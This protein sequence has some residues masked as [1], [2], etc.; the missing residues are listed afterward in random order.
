[1]FEVAETLV[2]FLGATIVGVVV[3]E[4]LNVEHLLRVLF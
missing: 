4:V 2:L 1:M 3:K